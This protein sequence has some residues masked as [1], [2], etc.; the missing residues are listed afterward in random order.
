VD[1]HPVDPGHITDIIDTA[2]AFWQSKVLLSAV[3]LELFTHLGNRALTARELG[4]ALGLHERGRADFLDALVALGYLARDGSGEGARYRNL[5]DVAVLL[6]KNSPRYLGGLLEMTNARVYRFWVDFTEALR[7]GAPQNE[8]KRSGTGWY[9]TLYASREL[10]QQFLAAMAGY[11]AG[12]FALLVERFPFDAYGSFCDVGGASGALA[13]AVARRHPSV[14]CITFDLP[15]VEPIAAQTVRASGLA[16]R[17]AVV[18][19][20][21]TVDPLPRAGVIAMGN[22]LHNWGLAGKTMLV[23]KAFE[24]LEPGGAFI[25]VEHVIDSERTK[26]WRALLMS[27]NMLVETAEGFECTES[28]FDAWCR[29]A[30]YRSTSI[31]PL[32]GGTRAAI[33][34]K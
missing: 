9:E 29:A 13:I 2:L 20:D 5:P 12:N 19:G 8:T 24:A 25:A 22:V 23:R 18:S 21:F 33:A 10:L 7:T 11:Q 34:Y 17:I 30:G 15:A 14:R 1:N 6:D 27:L 31:E 16:D 3:E 28:Q 26:N 4:D 32:S